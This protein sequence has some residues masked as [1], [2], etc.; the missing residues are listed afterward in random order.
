MEFNL[1]SMEEALK[2][3]YPDLRPSKW[4]ED[5]D[6][7]F[8]GSFQTRSIEKIGLGVDQNSR[9]E[10]LNADYDTISKTYGIIA[11]SNGYFTFVPADDDHMSDENLFWLEVYNFK[12]D[13]FV[14]ITPED[15][16]A[17]ATTL[18]EENPEADAVSSFI[19]YLEDDEELSEEELTFVKDFVHT[20]LLSALNN[21]IFDQHFNK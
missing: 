16:F 11:C 2:R 7:P 20:A 10:W 17:S 6:H 15:I 9:Y 18:D 4:V 5:S 12:Y 13:G 1:E 3:L 8:G 21:G 19:A 14:P